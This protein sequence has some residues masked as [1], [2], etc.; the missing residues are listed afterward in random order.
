MKVM[1]SSAARAD[2]RIIAHR[3]ARDNAER[4]QSFNAELVQAAR[5]L[6][7]YPLRY[8]LIDGYEETGYRKLSYGNY[9][10]FYLAAADRVDIVRILHGSRDYEAELFPE[11]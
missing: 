10:I 9:L 7:D 8:P 1:I 2:L 6:S 4:A 5:S 11:D 3:I